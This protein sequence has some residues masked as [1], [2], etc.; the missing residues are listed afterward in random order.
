ML[1]NHLNK[2]LVF[3]HGDQLNYL[4]YLNNA[5]EITVIVLNL[6]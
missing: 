3:I 2:N 5:E 4:H 6:T 1:S